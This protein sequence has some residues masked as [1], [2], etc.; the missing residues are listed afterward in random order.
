MT[1]G[2]IVLD[3]AKGPKPVE[4]SRLKLSDTFMPHWTGWDVR[5]QRLVVSGSGPR[6]FLVKPDPATGSLAMDAAFQDTDWKAGF[7]FRDREWPHG[8]KGSGIP[9]GVVFSR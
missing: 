9:H 3:I 5:T 4:V 6:L 2:L 1:H 7:N 8:R